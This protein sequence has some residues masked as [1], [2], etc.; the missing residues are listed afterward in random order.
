MAK[1]YSWEISKTPKRYAYIVNPQDLTEV[2][3]GIELQGS[4][5]EKVKEWA[6]NCTETQYE[7]Q[8]EKM[9]AA[10]A[11]QGYNVEFES[12]TAYMNVKSSCDNL[13]GADGR[14]IVS[15]GLSRKDEVQNISVYNIYYTDGT[16]DTFEVQNG[17]NGRDGADGAPGA[18][19][20]IVSSKLVMIYTSGMNDGKSPSRPSSTDGSYNFTKNVFENCPSGWFPNDTN[21]N[22]EPLTPPIWMSSRVFASSPDSTDKQWSVPIQITGENGL[23]GADGVTTEFIY[24]L[25]AGKPSTEYLPSENIPG[26]VPDEDFGWTASPTGV[27]EKNLTEWCS[28]RKMDPKTKIW[29]N[30]QEAFIW[31]KY[32]V[33][34]QDGDGVQYIY[35]KNNSGTPPLNPTPQIYKTYDK[36]QSRDEEWMPPVGTSYDNLYNEKV[37]Y[38]EEPVNS[39]SGIWTDNP[40][41]VTAEYPFLWVSSRKYRKYTEGN[42]KEWGAF[43]DPALWSR[44]GQDG[45]NATSI[46]KLYALSTST[47]TPPEL[48]NDSLFTRNW[49]TGFPV[50]Y[51]NGEDVVWGTEAEIWAHNNE[52]VMSYKKVSK[53]GPDGTPEPPKGADET[54]SFP[55][56][57]VPNEEVEGYDY[58]I[59]QGDYYA[60]TGGWC[61]PYL[62]TGVKGEAASPI[63]Y[64]IYVF[65]FGYADDTPDPPTGNDP[66]Q[67]NPGLDGLKWYD[68]PDTS[69]G[70]TDG[71]TVSGRKMRWYQCLG[72][73]D[74]HTGKVE[75]GTTV[76]PCNG[77]DGA[78][79]KKGANGNYVEMRFA[80]TKDNKEPEL[81]ETDKVTGRILREPT[82]YDENG[83]PIGWF[84][85]DTNLPKVTSTG[86]MWQI[87]ATI[88]G[89]KD[90]VVKV[91]D[92]YW[93]GPRRVSGERGAQGDQGIPGPAGKKGVTGI[94]GA[95]LVTM[96]CLGTYDAPFGSDIHKNENVLPEK[97]TNWY[98]GTKIPQVEFIK[99]EVKDEGDG[100]FEDNIKT[101]IKTNFTD[102]NIGRVIKLI[103]TDKDGV[104]THRYYLITYN[105]EAKEGEKYNTT[106]LLKKDLTP[107]ESEEY[108]IYIWCIQGSEIWEAGAVGYYV[109]VGTTNPED[110]DGNTSPDSFAK[111]PTT[112]QGDYK[113][114]ICNDKYYEWQEI[115][116]DEVKHIYAGV[117]WYIPFILQGTNGLRG[118]TGARGQVVY[119]MGIYNSREVY[120]TTEDKAPYVY[121]P[122]DGQY[123]VYNVV[124]ED[125]AWVGLRPDDYKDILIHPSDAKSSYAVA[126]KNP[127]EIVDKV[128]DVKYLL[129][130][131][132][133]YIWDEK[134]SQYSIASKYKYSIDGSKHEGTIWIQDQDGDTP[135]NNYANNTNQNIKPAWVRF[136]SF[137]A[138][139]TSIGIIENGMIGSAVYNNEFMFSQ[140][141]IDQDGK[142]T[143]YAVVS[144]EGTTYGFLSGYEYDEDG[145]R[146]KYRGSSTYIDNTDVDPYEKNEN[147]DYIHTFMPNVCINFATGQM[148]TSCGKAHFNYDGTGHLA[149]NAIRWGYEATASDP[150]KKEIA[151]EIGQL[152]NNGTGQGIKYHDGSL[153]IGPFNSFTAGVT[154]TING[155]KDVVDGFQKQVDKKIETHY[156]D[157]DPSEGWEDSDNEKHVG[158][159][160]YYTG[161]TT[162]TYKKGA[163][164]R[165]EGSTEKGYGW[166]ECPVPSEVFDRI[167]GK[168][169]IFTSIPNTEGPDGFLYHKN[170]LWILEQDYTSTENGLGVN[171]KKGTIWTATVSQVYVNSPDKNN[172]L[173]WG[174]WEI[175]A[176]YA[177]N[178]EVDKRVDEFAQNL[179]YGSYKELVKAAE[180]EDKQ[181]IIK[182]GHI[183]T[184]LIDADTLITKDAFVNNLTVSKLEAENLDS[185]K[186]GTKMVVNADKLEYEHTR[187][188][189]GQKSYVIIKNEDI[190]PITITHTKKVDTITTSNIGGTLCRL[191][192]LSKGVTIATITIDNV[193][194]GATINGTLTIRI[195]QVT[196]GQGNSALSQ[197]SSNCSPIL[198][199]D[200]TP[201]IN[202]R[203]EW[204][205]GGN[206]WSATAT[207]G[208]LPNFASGM[209][210]EMKL[211]RGCTN[212]YTDGTD[213]L[214]LTFTI[215]G[216]NSYYDTGTPGDG[217]W[218][219]GV[220][221]SGAYSGTIDTSFTPNISYSKNVTMLGNNGISIL[222]DSKNISIN[223]DACIIMYGNHGI[224]IDKNGIYTTDSAG[225]NWPNFQATYVTKS[226]MDN[227]INSIKSSYVKSSDLD[228][229][230]KKTDI[231]LTTAATGNCTIYGVKTNATPNSIMC[232]TTVASRNYYK[233]NNNT[234]SF[235]ITDFTS[236]EK[237][238]IGS[239][240]FNDYTIKPI[241]V[242][243]MNL[244]TTNSPNYQNFYIIETS[245]AETKSQ[246][247]LCEIIKNDTGESC[248]KII[249][250][251]FM[252]K[253]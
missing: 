141:G 115:D 123:Y 173:I 1:V 119:P 98:E 120:I 151:L 2:Y 236:Y 150:E 28:L 215:A 101:A 12:V 248:R 210:W 166:N 23:P 130:E 136:E 158:D 172:G 191:Y 237:I 52:F 95:S 240:S 116:S 112:K 24:Y 109:A 129:Y 117:R 40:S 46:R 103:K 163:T 157:S 189:G 197:T 104:E 241:F 159:L 91:G 82:L 218:L 219:I 147:G 193:P 11:S 99:V 105:K 188:N 50:D 134:T 81:I 57:E 25:G 48:P 224:K 63:D 140:Q 211:P 194:Y 169:S 94:P 60:W 64:T 16:Y 90:T 121:D 125:K 83:D 175:K 74:G 35:L 165:Y 228:G 47:S 155:L 216:K 253:S 62:V 73:V 202:V 14:G 30:W 69:G 142:P 245:G 85:T 45:K 68:F 229:Y 71:T 231:A 161:D 196:N 67:P 184:S 37:I 78:D 13:R 122:N 243:I 6:K 222:S 133:Y 58:I 65:C 242:E 251:S 152:N 143:N 61:T 206:N 203:A 177:D 111:L 223:D 180:A 230:V 250:F 89:E 212:V 10:C 190:T 3:I 26:Y 252:K 79:G 128:S 17:F 118:L 75:W 51:V 186:A 100:K 66:L 200:E 76:S 154:D 39:G 96:Y 127:L 126:E 144:G 56:D 153:T 181:T 43:S 5:L 93:N 238:W 55:M 246:D 8:F 171:G 233:L 33:N 156:I 44:F 77:S 36:Y 168:T 18:K 214:T 131:G 182:N 247:I 102:T 198:Y 84:T 170:D 114:I 54:N 176:S 226:S 148:W 174:D 239:L 227:E 27:D 88:D 92:K 70:R 80:V 41:N 187:H 221:A 235:M 132:K 22:G 138:L 183:N 167:D 42:K 53:I 124:G 59:V 106:D 137:E 19:G 207:Y 29:G 208:S 195:G 108:K 225:S 72:R 107:E 9:V 234:I 146:W 4:K 249:T 244:G 7:T 139:Y 179:G 204:A 162:E 110:A 149:D 192:P 21:I 145:K 31:S 209:H 199:V 113:Y 205:Q 164:Y 20:D 38:V 232:G 32:G 34:G 178:E 160:W 135:A 213:T 86:A 87:W 15:V 97:L 185:S 217:A 220:P 201:G 49:G